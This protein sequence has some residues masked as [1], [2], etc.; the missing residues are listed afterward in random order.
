MCYRGKWFEALARAF[1]GDAHVIAPL[2][3]DYLKR[4]RASARIRGFTLDSNGNIENPARLD[5]EAKKVAMI[6]I[7]MLTPI[8]VAVRGH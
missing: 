2:L 4:F 5:E 8:K 6:K 7:R 3:P 1:D